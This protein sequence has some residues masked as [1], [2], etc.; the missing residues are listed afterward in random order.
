MAKLIEVLFNT[1]HLSD[2]GCTYRVLRRPVAEHVARSMTVGGSHAG[3]EI[4]LLAITSGVRMVEVPLNYLPRVGRL[5]GHRQPP[6][7]DPRRAADAA[8]DPR[9]PGAAARAGGCGRRP[10]PW[11]ATRRMSSSHF[12]E[13][14]GLYDESLPAHVVEHY[15]RKRV[16]YVVE[17]CPP[18]EGSRR[19]LRNGRAG[20]AAGAGRLSR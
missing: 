7:G 20:V 12:D 15:L 10:S 18:G 8:A 14:A 2:V 9:A 4:M 11:C 6:G 3:A 16:R 5:L 17:H 19:R 1:N 13:I